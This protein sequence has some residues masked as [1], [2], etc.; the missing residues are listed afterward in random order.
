MRIINEGRMLCT[1]SKDKAFKI[2]EWVLFIGLGIVSGW[3]ASDVLDQFFSRM[4]S[5]AQYEEPLNDYPVIV[6]RFPWQKSINQ[7]DVKILYATKGIPN[8]Q[9]LEIGENHLYNKVYN[10]TEKVI[11][12]RFTR[13]RSFRIIPA[14][15]ILE[16]NRAA[17]RILLVYNARNKTN[18]KFSGLVRFYVTSLENSPGFANGKWKDGK[19]LSI[20]MNKNTL[21]AYYIQPQITKYLKETGKCQKE[22][23]Y[24][25]I[26]GQLDTNEVNDCPKK[27]IP[28]VFANLGKNYSTSFCQNDTSNQECL[29]KQILEQRIG[30]G[31]KTSCAHLEYIGELDINMPAIQDCSKLWSDSKNCRTY[32]LVYNLSNDD[33]LTKVYKEYFIYDTI[34]MMGSVGGTLGS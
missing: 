32:Y 3:F 15:P 4:T 31:C 24:E 17:V 8:K 6:I 19:P 28:D 5:F 10:K 16:K 14:T 23:Y 9:F 13:E 30:P 33:Y 27:C 11:L 25:C 21:N 12:E 29:V 20:T 1:I 26:L 34:G 2:L 7:E 18:F 22:P